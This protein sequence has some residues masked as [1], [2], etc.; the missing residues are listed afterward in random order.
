[1]ST[2]VIKRPIRA[3]TAA[4][5]PAMGARSV[6]LEEVHTTMPAFR[7]PMNAINRPIPA[8]MACLMGA[9]MASMILLRRGETAT[10]KNRAPEISTMAKAFCQV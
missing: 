2:A 3:T 9:G 1:M 4:L 7:R 6:T 5:L 10:K 8:L